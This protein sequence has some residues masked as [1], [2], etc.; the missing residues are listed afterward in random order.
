[1]PSIGRNEPCYCGSGKKYKNCHGPIDAET[2]SAQRRLRQAPDTLLPKLME[3]LDRFSTELPGALHLF[4]NGAYN[5]QDVK[6]LDEHED[7]GSERF[8][9]WFA[10]DAAD[11]QGRTPVQRLQTEGDGLE[12]TDAETQVLAGWGDVRMQPYEVI[13]I[14]KGRGLQVQPLFGE[15]QLDL[16]DHKAAKRV[17]VGEVLIAHLIPASDVYYVAGAAAQLTPDTVQKLHEFANIHLEDLRRNKPDATLADLVRI[18]SYIFNHF[19]MALPR[20]EKEAGKLDELVAMTRAAL[21]VTVEQIGLGGKDEERST[22]VHYADADDDDEE[23]VEVDSDLD[24]NVVTG[25][26]DTTQTLETGGVPQTT[27]AASKTTSEY[28]GQDD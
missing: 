10:F 6:D 23:E 18:R 27:K 11:E 24:A 19:V 5:V 20:E 21:N 28:E 16:E 15:G 13:G 8:L 14:R 1:M 7:R 17:D 4:W 9:T 26:S 22:P 2:E 25:V 12:M 3:G